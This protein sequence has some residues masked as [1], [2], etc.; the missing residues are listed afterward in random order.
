MVKFSGK[1]INEHHSKVVQF[2]S[3][4]VG[5]HEGLLISINRNGAYC[6]LRS[7]LDAIHV[8]IVFLEMLGEFVDVGKVVTTGM[9]LA[10]GA[11]L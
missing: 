7:L 1:I 5:I 11:L 8:G 2:V 10:V 9:C 4:E 6:L 3:S